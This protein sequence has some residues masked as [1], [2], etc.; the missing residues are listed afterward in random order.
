MPIK[1]TVVFMGTPDFAV[2]A[3]NRLKQSGY[4]ILAVYTQPPRPQGRGQGVEKSPVHLRAESLSIPVY[5][6]VRFRD[7]GAI[8]TLKSL[9][10]DVIVVAAYGLLLPIDVLAIPPLGCVNIHASLL[11][12]WRGASPIQRAIWAGDEK[13][14]VTLMKMDTGL[15]T[16]DMIKAV[17]YPIAPDATSPDVSE[18]LSILGADLLIETLPGY[19]NGSI[20]PTPQPCANITLAPKITKE[21]GRLVWGND[22]A[23]LE[24]QIR[25]LRPWPGCFFH[26]ND[27]AIKVGSALCIP[28][29]SPHPP[30]VV[31]DDR[32]T[33][34]CGDQGLR[35]LTLQKPGKG[36]MKAADFLNGFPIPAGTQLL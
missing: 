4:T 28:Q 2:P 21:D 34:A 24:R 27:T 32:L 11:P 12:R 5:T 25:A 16:G 33:I 6:P 1:P 10:P 8:E 13:T 36:M 18:A 35:L 17:E 15:D 30:G 20:K 26:Y 29:P 23:Y 31:L 9:S 19:I 7:D 14:G 22:A 3:L